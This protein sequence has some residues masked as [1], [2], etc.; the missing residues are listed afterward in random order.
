MGNCIVKASKSPAPSPGHQNEHTQTPDCT[1]DQ[2]TLAGLPTSIQQKIMQFSDGVMNKNIRVLS[3]SFHQSVGFD[4]QV[5]RVTSETLKR[6]KD[7][8]KIKEMIDRSSTLY[9][10]DINDIGG[11]NGKSD[12]DLVRAAALGFNNTTHLSL[13]GGR[14]SDKGWA[15]LSKF[16]Q[17]ETLILPLKTCDRHLSYLEGL[18]HLKTLHLGHSSYISNDGIQRLRGL[19]NIENL[20]IEDCTNVG[21]SG[22]ENLK[23]FNKLK[24]LTIVDCQQI[25]DNG[26]RHLRDLT[27]LESL[28]ISGSDRLSNS[29][30]QNIFLLKKLKQLTLLCG[31]GI[32]DAAFLNL[33]N[34][35]ELKQL[36]L[37]GWCANC[38]T[39]TTL[40]HIQHLPDL[41]SLVLDGCTQ[42]TDNG[43]I[44]LR[45]LTKLKELKLLNCPMIGDAGLEH[46]NSLGDTKAFT[47][48]NCRH[49]TPTS[50][51]RFPFASRSGQ[52]SLGEAF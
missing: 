27:Q 43:L 15:T 42:L 22:L 30:V 51:K 25:C 52:R 4:L 12:V 6:K 14:L 46:I 41:E 37:G 23:S 49:T 20:W 33:K 17:L 39:D 19:N 29:G 18:D 8:K 5:L 32:T 13:E 36:T 40:E 24:C 34:L 9:T 38:I 16:A 21:S 28:T 48:T 44:A 35:P 1:H 26:M 47:V 7:R 50:V 45:S 2:Q 11:S 10:L 3:K 31:G